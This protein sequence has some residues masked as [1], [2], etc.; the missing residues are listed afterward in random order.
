MA[1]FPKTELLATGHFAGQLLF[2]LCK[3]YHK[4]IKECKISQCSISKIMLK[5]TSSAIAVIADR[6][7]C[8]ILTLFIVI[9][10]SQALNKKSVCCQSTDP[11]ITAD[12]CLQS[13][14]RTRH[15]SVALAVAVS[16]CVTVHG[17]VSL[18]TNEPCLFDSQ[19][20]SHRH[21][22]RFSLRFCGAFCG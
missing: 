10:T 13:A 2:L 5:T 12:L 19:P 21:L 8:S 17:T 6:T 9:A 4:N 11:T 7:A 3:Q 16:H 1:I 22:W 15:T 18:L 14:V 20:E